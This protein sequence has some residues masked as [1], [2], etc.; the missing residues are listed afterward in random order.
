MEFFLNEVELSLNSAN[1]EKLIKSLRH[2]SGSIEGS[3]QLPMSFWHCGIISGSRITFYKK[4]VNEFTES[5]K[6]KT[7]M[8]PM[9]AAALRS[10]NSNRKNTL[11]PTW[12]SL[13][14]QC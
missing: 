5:N 13:L 8:E 6:G 1:S 14:L 9:T 7:P 4:I 2:E 3:S 12:V 11:K 10:Q